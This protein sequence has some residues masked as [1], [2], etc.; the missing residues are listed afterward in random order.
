VVVALLGAICALAALGV[1]AQHPVA[2][3]AVPLFSLLISFGV[4]A[5][6]QALWFLLPAALPVMSFAPWTGWWLFDESD[7]L[8]LSCLAGAFVRWGLDLWRNTPGARTPWKRSFI[9][10]WVAL[11]LSLLIGVLRGLEGAGWHG[12]S[13]PTWNEAVYAGYDSAWNTARVAKSLLW[14]LLI[15]LLLHAP[16]GSDRSSPPRRVANGMVVGL[17]LVC[18]VAMWERV[19]YVGLFDFSRAYRTSAWFW[20]MHVGGGAIDAYLAMAVPFAAWAMWTSPTPSRWAGANLLMA[21]SVYMVLTTY[22][23]G[24]YLA[25]LI[26]LLFMGVT[27]WRFKLA[28]AIGP[29]WGRRTLLAMGSTLVLE[30]AL[31]LGGGTFMADRLARSD[32]DLVGRI[33]H[34]R[35]SVSLLDSPQAWVTGL[36]MGRFPANYSRSV[37]G[38]HFPGEALWRSDPAGPPHVWLSGKR[39]I[40][41]RADLF[42][43]TQ[44]I[45]LEGAGPVRVRLKARGE[46]GAKLLVSLCER[47][48]LYDFACQWRW[49][50]VNPSAQTEAGWVEFRMGTKLFED[51]SG[52]ARLRERVIALSPAQAGQAIRI[53][54]LEMWDSS[55]RQRLRNT[56]FSQGL[57]HWLPVS[58]GQFQP[59]H[60]DNL[61]LDVLVERGLLG[62]LVLAVWVLWALNH[63][64]T[65]LRQGDT[66]AW[67]LAASLVGLLS[68]G[69]VISVTEVP[70]VSLI[71]L[72]LLWSSGRFR[73]QMEGVSRCN[74]L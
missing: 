32:A 36:G 33:E 63:L 49:V 20:E 11:A 8:V 9:L 74:Q 68:L 54:G 43:L 27:A 15:G 51:R 13:V 30:S 23:R 72:I 50:S 25:A 21:L 28:P 2:P 6:P 55:G 17:A 5:R 56:D 53:E 4:A 3:L 66:V 60:T 39:K 61:Y 52:I 37:E 65:Q 1:A 45:D 12:L 26:A 41:Q 31:V 58:Q 73:G 7:I 29:S 24:V 34:W 70:R 22:S 38:G 64:W 47:H 59:W 67:A 40:G 71:L 69:A 44:R 19:V 42:L 35:S 48:L 16:G 57:Q 14:A 46:P 62:L 10:L 18:L